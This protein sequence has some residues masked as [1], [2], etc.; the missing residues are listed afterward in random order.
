MN[1]DRDQLL[2]DVF[3]TAT[4]RLR[5]KK[6]PV[7]DRE[8]ADILRQSMEDVVA[9]TMVHVSGTVRSQRANLYAMLEEWNKTHGTDPV[10][11]LAGRSGLEGQVGG[12]HVRH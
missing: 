7:G 9:Q 3:E 10:G 11:L 6:A 12:R 4:E 2:T 1:F 8:L 5:A